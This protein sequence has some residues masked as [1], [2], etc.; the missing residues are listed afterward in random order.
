M[1][2]GVDRVAGDE[3]VEDH[4][5][6]HRELESMA[7]RLL[8]FHSGMGN[9]LALARRPERL[10]E[11]MQSWFEGAP[12]PGE[13]FGAS[14]GLLWF[15]VVQ[16]PNKAGP[17]AGPC[18]LGSGW[19]VRGWGWA[20]NGSE[21]A[22]EPA[23]GNEVP[24]VWAALLRLRPLREFWVHQVRAG[25]V[26][27][28]AQVLAPSWIEP[29]QPLP[30]GA[31]LPGLAEWGRVV[32]ESTTMASAPVSWR[33]QSLW[34]SGGPGVIVPPWP[35]PDGLVWRVECALAESEHRRARLESVAGLA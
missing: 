10:P 11:G 1:G 13:I 7:Y 6:L 15:D 33:R 8:R 25:H 19:R 26:A 16:L 17:D 20:G 5:A 21:P 24:G 28:L 14:T 32:G 12:G 30:A 35:V 2:A 23:L 9:L 22:A 27:A 29:Q 34:R 3:L 18:G 31:L 4:A